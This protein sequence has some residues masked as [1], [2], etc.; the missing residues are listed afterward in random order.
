MRSNLTKIFLAVRDHK[1]GLEQSAHTT[2][3]GARQQL[4]QW[5]RDSLEVWA[6]PDYDDYTDEQLIESWGEITGYNEY[7]LVEILPLNGTT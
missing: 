2:H 7:L 1:K 3:D 4:A 5:A 6:D